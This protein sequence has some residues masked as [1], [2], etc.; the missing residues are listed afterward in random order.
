MFKAAQWVLQQE[1][2]ILK[3]HC[4]SHPDYTLSIVGHSLGAGIASLLL[5]L[6]HDDPSKVRTS[7][8]HTP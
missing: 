8:F 5:V 2:R 1:E 6:L 7:G 4:A 3:K